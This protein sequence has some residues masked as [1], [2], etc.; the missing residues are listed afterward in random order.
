MKAQVIPRS[1]T[2]GMLLSLCASASA[3]ATT[4]IQHV[5]F[6]VMENHTFDN[7]FGT[8]P[9][10][11]GVTVANISTG[12]T[13][14]LLHIPDPPPHGWDPS[15]TWQAAEMAIDDG[16]MDGFNLISGCELGET[17]CVGQ[18][19]EADIPNIW[20]Y[21]RNFALSDNFFTSL[22]GPSFPNHLYTIAGQSA[23]AINNPNGVQWGC[24]APS[25][26]TVQSLNANNSTY[27]QR[28]CFNIPTLMSLLDTA[29]LSWRYYGRTSSKSS[30]GYQWVAPDAI[31]YIRNGP[32][33]KTNVMNESQFA[34]DA[35]N[36]ALAMVSW[37]TPAFKTSQH[38][39]SSVCEGENWLV[40]QVSSVMTGPDWSSTAIFVTWDDFGGFY[41]HVPP[42][43]IDIY[44]LGPRVPVLIISP[45]VV[46]GQIYKV[47]T[48]FS[49][50]LKQTEEWFG[51]PN[52]GARD[53]LPATNDFSG[54]F[55]FSQAPLAPLVL[56]Q[57]TCP[58]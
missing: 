12:E 48:E 32:E 50:V 16:K 45:W 30:G 40:Q 9:G 6:I 10:A 19:Y 52:L 24:D 1:A 4:P 56:N 5:V 51:L 3:A 20:A 58:K 25:G 42:P 21:A 33:W 15:H 2:L 11:N 41:D 44:G 28:P 47:Q 53:A 31:S 23:G 34:A 55:N 46:A 35:V 18:Y 54:A 13:E 57:R 39:A 36:G 14:A 17:S 43:V 29:G 22:K 7:F 37:L 8:Y 26:V 49:S 27:S 38:P